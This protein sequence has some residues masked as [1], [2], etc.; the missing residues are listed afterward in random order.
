M[1]YV[2]F[3]VNQRKNARAENEQNF[4][5]IKGTLKL[6]LVAMVTN[7]IIFFF[8]NVSISYGLIFCILALCPLIL[9]SVI[10]CERAN[11]ANC[12]FHGRFAFFIGVLVSSAL[13]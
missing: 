6:Y 13:V 10:Y 7:I 11:I 3:S 9:P 1:S 5:N 4:K 12:A 2:S 8:K